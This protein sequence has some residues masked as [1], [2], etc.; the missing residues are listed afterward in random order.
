MSDVEYIRSADDDDEA[1]KPKMGERR[2]FQFTPSHYRRIQE[3]LYDH[4][5]IVLGNQKQNLA[6]SR[7]VR[8]LRD[9]GLESFDAYFDYVNRHPSEFPN[10]INAL[11]TNLTSFFREKHH[12][13]FIRRVLIPN[14]RAAEDKRIMVWSAGCSEGH[15]PY[16]LAMTFKEEISD[17][18]T[19]NIR[20]LA[21]DIDSDILQT[22]RYGEYMAERVAK[23]PK[24][25]IHR[26]FYRGTGSRAGKVKIKAE[27]K[28]FIQFRQVNLIATWPIKTPLDMVFYRNVMI[29]FDTQTQKRLLDRMAE[30]VKP[31]GYLFIGHSETIPSDMKAFKLVGQT[32]YQRV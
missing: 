13:D 22:A 20:I 4:A 21:T 1:V 24:D 15:E 28:E 10:F 26:W 9:L 11:T 18:L 2:E 27:L 19:W 29:Y 14:K 6:Y 25:Q 32:I 8:R 5:G 7:I 12:F 31:G 17:F 30:K 3:A 23:L 16:S